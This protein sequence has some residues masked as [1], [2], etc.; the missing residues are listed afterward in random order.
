[1][2]FDHRGDTTTSPLSV[3]GHRSKKL[4][5]VDLT[6][7]LTCLKKVLKKPFTS[8]RIGTIINIMVQEKKGGLQNANQNE[9]AGIDD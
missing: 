3:T 5:N 6:G 1:M 7:F 8:S 2:A 4:K 9:F